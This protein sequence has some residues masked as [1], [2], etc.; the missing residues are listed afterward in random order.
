M[1]FFV[2]L[3]EDQPETFKNIFRNY[4]KRVSACRR[5]SKDTVEGC[6]TFSVVHREV[7]SNH[8]SSLS[9]VRRALNFKGYGRLR[10]AKDLGLKPRHIQLRLKYVKDMLKWSDADYLNIVFTDE[11]LFSCCAGSNADFYVGRKRAPRLRQSDRRGKHFG[12]RGIMVWMGYSYNYGLFFIFEGEQGA[13]VNSEQILLAYE[14]SGM[15]SFFRSHRKPILQMD[16]APTHSIVKKKYLKRRLDFPPLSPDL[17][18]VETGR[19]AMSRRV[20]DVLKPRNRTQLRESIIEI[21]SFFYTKINRKRLR[22]SSGTIVNVYF[23]SRRPK[24]IRLNTRDY[25]VLIFH[26]F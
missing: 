16:N 21:F 9:S 19:A 14:E 23:W 24:G 17:N 7:R 1:K 18:P 2:F 11:K 5:V 3:S 13:S 8:G 12:V 26:V 22:I 15:A 10:K 6:P 4:C 20:T 25:F